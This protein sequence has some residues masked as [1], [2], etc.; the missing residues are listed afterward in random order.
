MTAD[1]TKKNPAAL[2][3]RPAGAKEKKGQL[4]KGLI[5]FLTILEGPSLGLRPM[6]YL[7]RRI[8]RGN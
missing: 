6:R 7:L 8:P 1:R 2:E 4:G 5:F 3:I